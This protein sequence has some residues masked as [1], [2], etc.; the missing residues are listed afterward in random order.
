MQY[1][2]NAIKLAIEKGGYL[3]KL[4]PIFPLN[5][6]LVSNE[7]GKAIFVEIR[8]GSCYQ[9]TAYIFQ[10]PLFWQ[11]LGKALGWAEEY[12]SFANNWRTNWHRYI[13]CLAEGNDTDKFWKDLLNKEASQ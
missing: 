8:D 6:Q 4:R 5:T 2:N 10:D 12:V 13:D 7:S 9:S 1:L 3:S 11:A